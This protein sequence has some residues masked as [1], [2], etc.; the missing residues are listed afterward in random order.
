LPSSLTR[1]E[2]PFAI[3]YKAVAHKQIA[4]AMYP[5]WAY[6]LAST[7]VQFPTAAC[8]SLAFSTILYFM[9]GFVPGMVGI[10]GR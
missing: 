6:S 8:E 5:A 10:R 2:I 1:A 9:V 3:E 7:L 4:L